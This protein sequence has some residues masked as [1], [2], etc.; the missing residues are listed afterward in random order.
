MTD[1]RPSAA[2]SS[3]A[4]L[5]ARTSARSRASTTSPS[6]STRTSSS[7]CSAR[8]AAA[9]PPAAVLAG[10]EPRRRDRSRLAGDD[11]LALPAAP[12]SGQPDVPVVRAVPAHERR[13]QLAYG[14]ERE[15]RPKERCAT[16]SPRSLETVGLAAWRVGVRPALRRPAPRVALA[17]AIVKRPRLLLLD[18]PLSALD[19]KVRGEM[20]LELKRLQH[21]VGITFVVVTRDQDEALSM[22]DRIAADAIQRGAA[23][24]QLAQRCLRD[25]RSG[26]KDQYPF[27]WPV[28]GLSADPAPEAR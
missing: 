12:A 13:A 20:Q 18:E 5:D 6:T 16:A 7:R 17:R 23:R 27:Q 11:L 4:P 25:C 24:H 14:L 15:G 21:E 22:A 10:F 9:R 3:C 1:R 19:R 8:R 2:R 28:H 26:A